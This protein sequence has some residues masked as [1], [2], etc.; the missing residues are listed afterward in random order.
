MLPKIDS[1][2][3]NL[4]A[5]LANPALAQSLQNIEG[6]T[7]NLKTTSKQLNVL[8]ADLNKNVPGLLHKANGVLTNADKFLKNNLLTIVDDRMYLTEEG[9]FV[10]DGIMSSLIKL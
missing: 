7:G 8:M 2:L 6:I 10:S 9:I 1:I 3:T 5:L 4:N